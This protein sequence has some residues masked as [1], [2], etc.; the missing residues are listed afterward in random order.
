MISLEQIYKK[1]N[2]TL[3]ENDDGE[4]IIGAIIQVINKRQLFQNRNLD[5]DEIER[6]LEWRFPGKHIKNEFTNLNH[7][8]YEPYHHDNYNKNFKSSV[9][10]EENDD[11][12]ESNCS[13][14]KC[15]T[16]KLNRYVI[17]NILANGTDNEIH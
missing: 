9:L 15:K 10:E 3:L 14:I 16:Q 11:D 5:P 7:L 13:E 8:F 6:V 17:H 2:V 12:G 1:K 4:K